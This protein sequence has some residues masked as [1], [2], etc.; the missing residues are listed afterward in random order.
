MGLR[1]VRSALRG[2]AGAIALTLLFA[3]APSDAT[4]RQRLTPLPS[5]SLYRYEGVVYDR[6]FSANVPRFAQRPMQEAGTNGRRR[7]D[8]RTRLRI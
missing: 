7:S 2:V 5:S 8:R 3:V 4:S 6:A 1:F